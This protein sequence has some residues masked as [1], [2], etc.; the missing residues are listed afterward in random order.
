MFLKLFNYTSNFPI[1]NF[2]F[3]CSNIP[4]APAYVVYI[5]Q[6]IR[7]FRACGS[8]HDFLDRGLLLTRKLLNQGF[9]SWSH[10]F[11]SFT[12]DT[13]ATDMLHLLQT[14]P[15][16]FLIHDFSPVG[17]KINTTGVTSEEETP[18][19]SSVPEVTSAHSEVSA[20]WSSVLCK[21]FIDRCKSF[22]S[23]F[24][25]PLYYLSFLSIYGLWLSL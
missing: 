18:Y 14:L 24:F 23:F 2:P 9:L 4:V 13:I 8:N 1:V 7:Y 6:L 16:P 21:C 5:S 22:C 10:H 19:P 15:G 25:W 3:I 17:N 12:V 11:E 20:S